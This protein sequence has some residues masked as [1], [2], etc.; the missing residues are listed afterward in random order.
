M[1]VAVRRGKRPGG[2]WYGEFRRRLFFERD[3]RREYSVL[4][5]RLGQSQGLTGFVYL[6]TV[7][8]PT[9]GPRQL[10]IVFPHRY[11]ENPRVFAEGPGL[12][13]HRFNDGS[14]C[15]WYWRD[16]PERKWLFAEGLLALINHAIVHLFKKAWFADNGEWLGDEITHD[17]RKEAA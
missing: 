11:P 15:M 6:V 5:G 7:E 13:R 10:T 14:L 4:R 9:Y 3:A 16:S 1:V 8:V 17:P 12:N 2:P